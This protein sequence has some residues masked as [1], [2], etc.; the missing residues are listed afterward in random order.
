[1]G[2]LETKKLYKLQLIKKKV[3]EEIVPAILEDRRRF[4]LQE[5]I[6]KRLLKALDGELKKH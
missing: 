3:Y 2:N 6:E 1:M 4:T 5:L